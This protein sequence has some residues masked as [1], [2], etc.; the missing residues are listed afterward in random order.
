MYNAASGISIFFR[1]FCRGGKDVDVAEEKKETWK[2]YICKIQ[3]T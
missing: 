3:D 2:K 1:L